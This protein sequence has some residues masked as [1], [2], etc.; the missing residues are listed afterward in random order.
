MFIYTYLNK[1]TKQSV[2]FIGETSETWQL[3][4]FIPLKFSKV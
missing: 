3:A 1:F 2:I 4:M